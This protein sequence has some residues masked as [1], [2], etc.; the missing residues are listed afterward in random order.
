MSTPSSSSDRNLI[1]GLLALQM[2]F[3]TGEQL[4]DALHA[5]MLRKTTP[6]GEILRERG[7]LNER[8]LELLQGMVEEHIAQHGGNAQAS[9]AAL[10]VDGAVRDELSRIEDEQVQ[11]SVASLPPA[12][13][14]VPGAA[15]DTGASAD[16]VAWP[17]TAAPTAPTFVNSRF[18]RLREHARG[19]LGEVFV[20]LDTD[21]NREVALKEIQDR[22]AD[23]P[24]ARA[25]FLRE[26]EVT[27][28]L[29]HP[30]VVPVYGLG[31]YPDGR[32]YY[33]MRFIRGESMHAAIQRFHQADADPRRDQGERSLA[34]RELLGRFVMVC[35]AVA[36]AHSRGVIHRDLKPA[37]A[38]LGE[39]GETLVV[40]WGLARLLDQTAGEETTAE[41]PM[42]LGS[43]SGTAA[44]QM[45][46]VVG[47]AAYMPPEQAEGQLD[48]VGTASDVFS[49]GGTLYTLL[50]GQA[51][52]SGEDMLGQ[53]RRATVLPARQRKAS[54]PVALDA[55]CSKAMARRPENRYPTARA[56]AEEMQRWLA[57]EPVQAYRE[58]VAD[59]VRRWSRRHRTLVSGGAALLV[60]SVVALG[61]GLWFV[62]TEK[63]KTTRQRD[64]AAVAEEEAQ[65]N[66]K[67]ARKAIDDCFNI[68]RNDP[69]FQGPRMEN[70][71]NLLL[72]ETLPFY[73]NFRVRQPDDRELQYE[74][75]LQ[76]FRVGYIEFELKRTPQAREAYER[77]RELFQ[78][79][80]KTA[81][82][83]PGYRNDLASTHNNMALVLTAL[84]QPDQALK[85][86]EAARGVL[87]ELIET[88]P[89]SPEF[90]L[91]LAGTHDQMGKLLSDL[92]QSER[93]LAEFQQARE[94]L[95][96]LM[97][98][99]PGL[100]ECR[101][102]LART[103][104]NLGAL[105]TQ[106]GKRKEALIE[107]QEAVAL[108]QKLISEQP[109]RPYNQ[110]NLAVSYLNL[111][112]LHRLMGQREQ[113][114]AEYRQALKLREKLVEVHP[115]LP[116]YQIDLTVIHTNL[117]VVL[118]ELG[119]SDEA[120]TEYRQA[121]D[122]I[123]KLVE[124]HPDLPAYQNSLAQA[125][126]NLGAL[127]REL[128]RRPEALKE[129]ERSR[130]IMQKLAKA[131]PGLPAY[132]DML[133][134]MQSNLGVLLHELGRD[135]DAL[136]EYRQAG[137]LQQ[138]LAQAYAD[139]PEHQQELARTHE[140]LGVLL[141]ALGRR[142][143]ALKEYGQ[144]R[145]LYRK[146]VK[147]HPDHLENQRE[148]AY[149]HDMRGI[150]LRD[151][152]RAE[153]ALVEYR[154]AQELH[155]KLAQAN[156]Q[157]VVHRMDLAG[158]CCNIGQLLRG[159]GKGR[160]SLA[161]F[162]RAVELLEKAR[163]QAP[164]NSKVLLYVRNSYW[165]RAQAL[166]Q[167]GRYGEAAADWD[168]ALRLENGPNRTTFRVRR[169][170]SHA[171]A[172]GYLRAAAETAELAADGEIPGAT[173]YDLACIQGL[174][175]ASAIRDLRRPLPERT[176]RSEE[177]ARQAVALLNRAAKMGL[178]QDPKRVEH[179]DKDTDLT[180][181]LERDDYR[182]FRQSLRP[183]KPSVPR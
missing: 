131:H 83:F 50:T 78:S 10:R 127:L 70:A 52:Y 2:D 165:G 65:A 100:R 74:E 117:G 178:F 181:L 99:H 5:W 58:P 124:A 7:W 75:A 177:Y 86:H 94:L 81:P 128:N 154:T 162:G 14:G 133:A 146:L 173:L 22:F 114:L 119:K 167:L 6:V 161:L 115:D 104:T 106:M 90:E 82:D 4:L 23:H 46:Q 8:R 152:G 68:A 97:K 151:L 33:A 170:D 13:S 25:R 89:D 71:R 125:H 91:H 41:R 150:L 158:T 63:Q 35:N 183:T 38:M 36:Y 169:A 92:R 3:L 27:G 182:A 26:A 93:S 15:K 172:G 129:F 110:H 69:L 28:K 96:K 145:D 87:R 155:G 30:G 171:R 34:L 137:E 134:G 47:T 80:V 88:H 43:G 18:R 57:D 59:R 31:I 19:G 149:A 132:L 85:E 77:A 37:N 21:L 123:Q 29:E 98:A 147:A 130:D 164:G 62:N 116:E 109:D 175:T 24:D 118:Q 138:K 163:Q 73:R 140:N 122:R 9:L 166:D 157:A 84:G 95:H 45:G 42:Q 16:S 176:K 32:P 39:Y 143:D 142:E 144:V 72:R 126:S 105:L 102:D 179:L 48:R 17:G 76:W 103:H 113:A 54:V 53:A 160:E 111:G 120:L 61:V 139:L 66:L 44:T 60:A 55:V 121:T 136:T 141:R 20:A 112:Q 51:P 156:P 40:D 49:L 108:G 101:H 67:L 79:L 180:T 168:Q 11:A 64:R 56:L 159:N 135:E 12:P 1:F 148:L 174:N 153:E 107:Y